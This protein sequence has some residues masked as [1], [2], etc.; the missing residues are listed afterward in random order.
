MKYIIITSINNITDAI[1]A[2]S[3]QKDWHVV[4][5]GDKKSTPYSYDNITYLSIEDQLELGYKSIDSTPYNHY[6]RKNIGYLYAIK[7]NASSIYDTDDDTFPYKDWG[8]KRF[9]CSAKIK[10][11][12]FIN[13]FKLFTEEKV[14]PRGLELSYINRTDQYIEKQENTSVGVWQGVIDGDSDFDAIYRLTVDKHVTFDQGKDIVIADNCYA[15]FNTQSTLWNPIFYSLLYVP[16]TVDFRFTDILRGYIA[17]RIM[18]EYGHNV[19]FHRPNTYQIRNAHDYFKD[20]LGEISMY[21]QVPEVIA[22]LDRTK[23]KGLSIQEDLTTVYEALYS[24]GVVTEE[25]LA[26]LSNWIS[27]LSCKSVE[28]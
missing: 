28:N 18:W 12:K 25:E 13:P 11:A 26:N 15:P 5:V 8:N 6:S 19:G 3:K 21:K 9:T 2:F 22:I 17:Q 16:I 7:N 24:I 1:I 27:D 20:F 23:L 10:G 14:W 4:V